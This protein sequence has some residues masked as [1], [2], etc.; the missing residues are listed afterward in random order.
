MLYVAWKRWLPRKFARFV[1]FRPIKKRSFNLL[2]V[3]GK[4][5]KV[6]WIQRHSF[7]NQYGPRHCQGS[8]PF[9]CGAGKNEFFLM[10]SVADGNMEAPVVVHV[11][12]HNVNSHKSACSRV[13]ASMPERGSVS[14][15]GPNSFLV[16][17]NASELLDVGTAWQN[18]R[19][20][21]WRSEILTN[22]K[23]EQNFW[24]L[25]THTHTHAHITLLWVA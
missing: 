25:P 22:C 1:L 11:T 23:A 13:C 17:E 16:S 4:E 3:F 21:P 20:I 5:K 9:H 24:H 6:R 8:V 12:V 7:G 18:Q 2:F 15:S 14:W 10:G 19:S